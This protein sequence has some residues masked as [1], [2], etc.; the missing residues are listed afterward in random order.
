MR[1]LDDSQFPVEVPMNEPNKLVE[2]EN[3]PVGYQVAANV[4]TYQGQI[5]WNRF[6][7]MWVHL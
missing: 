4:W 3:A 6:N 5:I 7:V 1:N 2:K